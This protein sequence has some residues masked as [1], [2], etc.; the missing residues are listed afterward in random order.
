MR[1]CVSCC[2]FAAVLAAQTTA[3][4]AVPVA[5]EPSHHL[6]LQNEYVRV[7][8]VEVA[9][10]SATL[11][12]GHDKDYVFV[13]LGGSEVSNERQGEKPV[14]LKLH[15]GETRFTKGGF[16]HVARN[17][18]DKPFRNVTIEL[19]KPA[20]PENSG[21]RI[22]IES[23]QSIDPKLGPKC[24]G[25]GLKQDLRQRNCWYSEATDRYTMSMVQLLPGANTGAHQHKTGHLVV[26]ISD[27]ELRSEI[28]GM[29]PSQIIQRAGDV[30]WVPGGFTHTLTNVGKKP[31]RFVTFEF[32]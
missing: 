6:A 9:P 31:A 7:F 20:P 1:M 19:L 28:T 25:H 29:P 22:V 21:E 5:D 2:F 30:K 17:L 24:L 4:A 15:D 8:K 26:A 13:T 18:S 11:L 10:R 23:T 27:L 14:T 3:P 32:E 16:A 12:H